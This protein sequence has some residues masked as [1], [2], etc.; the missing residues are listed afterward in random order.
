MFS[1]IYDF[2]SLDLS[3]YEFKITNTSDNVFDTYKLV[4][5]NVT[6]VR[7]FLMLLAPIFIISSTLKSK[8]LT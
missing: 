8:T 1:K 4:S 7:S 3:V 5:L 6:F 2:D